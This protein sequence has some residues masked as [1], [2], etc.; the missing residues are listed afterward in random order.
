MDQHMFAPLQRHLHPN[1]IP[2]LCIVFDS[3]GPGMN[4]HQKKLAGQGFSTFELLIS[5][6]AREVKC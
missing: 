5:Y 6:G 1:F 3:L 4:V 2:V